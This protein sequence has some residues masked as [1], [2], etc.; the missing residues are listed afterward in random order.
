MPSPQTFIFGKQELCSI[1][2]DLRRVERIKQRVFH[3]NRLGENLGIKITYSSV[4]ATLAI[5]F[6]VAGGAET[7]TQR[8]TRGKGHIQRAIG[9]ALAQRL[10]SAREP[11]A[12]LEALAQNQQAC[13]SRRLPGWGAW[14]LDEIW[15]NPVTQWDQ[16]VPGQNSNLGLADL[17]S[18]YM[19]G[20][21]GGSVIV[22]GNAGT[23]KTS[24]A[25]QVFK[26]LSGA[27]GALKF[28]PLYVPAQSLSF[29]PPSK[30]ICWGSLPGALTE[31]NTEIQN[32][33]FQEGGLTLL[34]D[35]LDEN[36]NIFD[37]TDPAVLAFWESVSRNRCLLTIRKDCWEK[38]GLRRL[39]R[40]FSQRP[41][42]VTLG[43]WPFSTIKLL[44]ARLAEIAGQHLPA[45]A[46]VLKHCSGLADAD[47]TKLLA[48]VPKTPLGL[49]AYASLVLNQEGLLPKNGDMV[50][51]AMLRCALSWEAAKQSSGI[52]TQTMTGLLTLVVG[53]A[54]KKETSVSS[55]ERVWTE[56]C[57]RYP[58]LEGRSQKVFSWLERLPFLSLDKER[59]CLLIEPGI[60]E[61]LTRRAHFFRKNKHTPKVFSVVIDQDRGVQRPRDAQRRGRSRRRQRR[62]P[63]P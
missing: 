28:Y 13:L 18:A 45:A 22:L 42:I 50:R 33:A 35:G 55:F 49:N 40:F 62:S 31:V 12:A 19:T 3:L 52:D 51:E 8:L 32:R 20:E 15:V 56:V 26:R 11:M 36:P 37:L 24:L 59:A 16:P 34:L 2:G 25:Y 61:F 48:M 7:L 57:R 39:E 29:S 44:F 54:Q 10:E 14:G 5:R 60:A 38:M 46:A 21:S 4:D 41:S 53:Q 30:G 63:N 47:L 23:G 43:D 17:I 58:Y 1:F 9:Q 6:P 27:S